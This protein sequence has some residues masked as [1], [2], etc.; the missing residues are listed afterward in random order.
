MNT[1]VFGD[2]ARV[3]A[4]ANGLPTKRYNTTITIILTE[5]LTSA[6]VTS[7]RVDVCLT[8]HHPDSLP[9]GSGRLPFFH[10][11]RFFDT[12]FIGEVSDLLQPAS[13]PHVAVRRLCQQ[14]GNVICASGTPIINSQF[15]IPNIARFCGMPTVLS[16]G[17]DDSMPGHPGTSQVGNGNVG[18][19]LSRG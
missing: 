6:M 11:R 3:P 1:L 2:E 19:V 14:A 17:N 9:L 16:Y 4:V 15:D 12:V 10:Q 5:R 13:G 7:L 8:P 18:R